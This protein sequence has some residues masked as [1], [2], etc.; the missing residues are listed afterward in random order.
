MHIPK[1]RLF[2]IA[3]ASA[4]ILG[5]SSAAQTSRPQ[6]PDV[7]HALLM[8][9][10]GLRV[11]IEQMASAGPRVELALGRLQL[12]EQRVNTMIRRHETLRETIADVEKNTETAQAQLATMEKMFKDGTP[13]DDNPM[14][15]MI[16]GL[17]NAVSSGS[18]NLQRLQSEEAQLQQQILNE[19][20]RWSAINRA[21]EELEKAFS[22]GG[23]R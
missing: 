19:Q 23:G 21:L 2:C 7:L 1:W 11:A 16:A 12:Q 8:E 17:R 13:L 3:L 9:V 15:Q 22:R 6:E 5:V 10:R 18:A 4:A 14:G 20:A